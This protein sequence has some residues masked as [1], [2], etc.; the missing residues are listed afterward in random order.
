MEIRQRALEYAYQYESLGT[1]YAW[2][3]QDPLPG[4]LVVDCSGLVIR[5]YQY[6]CEDFGFTLPFND[7]TSYGL[8]RYSQSIN[9]TLLSPGDLLFMGEDGKISHIALFIQ[10]NGDN[11]QFIDATL[12]PEVGINGVTTRQYNRTDSRFISYGRMFVQ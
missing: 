7:T 8:I 3:G 6:A 10:F 11:I 2:G 1:G 12:K 4:R 9:Q 5:C